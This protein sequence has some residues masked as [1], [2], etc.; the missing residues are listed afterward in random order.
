MDGILIIDKPAGMTSHDVVSRVRK[1]LGTRRVGHTGTLDPFA[2]GVM[3]VLVGKA[4]R[5]AQFLDKDMKE[6]VAD[7]QFGSQTDTGDRT[8]LRLPP[9]PRNAATP[10]KTGGEPCG[11]RNEDVLSRLADTDWESVLSQFRGEIMQTPPMFSAKKIAGKKLYEHARKGEVVERKPAFVVVHQ[12]EL[13]GDEFATPHS[14]LRIRVVCSAGTYVRTL[15]EDIGTAIGTGAHLLALRRTAAGRFTLDQS[16]TLDELSEL[17]APAKHLLSVGEAVSHLPEFRLEDD[18][19]EPTRN[20]LAT[21]VDGSEYADGEFLRMTD[22]R[23]SLIAVGS[24]DRVERS[25]HPKVVL[26]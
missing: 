10:P 21:R 26:A 15:A 8:G 11:L 9:R 3:V 22:G 2:T 19:I 6:Y 20:G 14:V 4:T 23:G 24:Y 25:I 18:R 17:A 13:L 1:I 16:I 5:L 7:V 12:L